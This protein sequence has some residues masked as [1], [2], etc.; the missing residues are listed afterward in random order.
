MLKMGLLDL[1][2]IADEY[3]GSLCVCVVF[4]KVRKDLKTSQASQDLKV[5]CKPQNI[6][7]DFWYREII[8]VR[9]VQVCI[10]R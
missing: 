5:S 4:L 7:L 10:N 6:I 3:D 1:D 8:R 9:N 2:G